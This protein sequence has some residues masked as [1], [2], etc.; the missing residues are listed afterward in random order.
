MDTFKDFTDKAKEVVANA[1]EAVKNAAE[2]AKAGVQIVAE[3]RTVDKLYRQ[4]GEWYYNEG[5]EGCPDAIRDIIE[6]INASLERIREWQA[7][8][9]N[10]GEA[11][12]VVADGTVCP[13]CGTAADSHYCPNCGT[14]LD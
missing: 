3:R 11:F 14:K 1:G 2:N 5:S 13:V 6:S 8:R 10:A 9:E 12:D 7:A 4:I